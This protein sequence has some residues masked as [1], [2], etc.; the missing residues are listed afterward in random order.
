MKKITLL[1][2][3]MA[4][5]AGFSQ[6]GRQSIQAYL[7]GSRDKFG[8]TNQ[9]VSDW[10]IENE[11][12]G[13]GTKVTSYAIVQ[14]YQGIEIF[15]AQS[16]VSFKDGKVLTAGNNFQSNI[17]GKVN[18]TAPV[19]SAIQAA[20]AA[21]S[22]VGISAVPNFAV[23]ETTSSQ[24]LKLTDGLQ[25]DPILAKLVYQP[26]TDSK[27][28]LA[29]AFQF[30][31]PDGKH[32][33]DLRI[34]A[35]NGT[36][37][38]KNDL[39]INCTFGDANHSKHNH[40]F[41]FAK[42]AFR[43]ESSILEVESG[44]YKVIP[45]NYSSPNHS[46][47]VTIT[48]PDNVL[49]SPW[50]WHDTN[51]AAGNEYTIT[52]GN[53]A[54]AY[55]DA[56]G[57]NSLGLTPDGT[58]TLNFDFPYG[59][60]TALP[61]TYTNAATTNL[62][63]MVNIMHDVWYQYGFDEANGNFQQNNY[64]RGGVTTGTGDYV[65]SEA[66]D[67]YQATAQTLNNA[68]FAPTAD[69]VRPR[70]QMFL[71]NLGAPPIDYITV[72]S[73]PAIAGPISTA[74]N[75]VFEGTDHIEVPTAPNGITADLVLV[76]NGPTPPGYNSA[77]Q[78]PSNAFDIA[79]K[80]A[81]IKRG[82]CLFAFK[83]KTAQD[84]GALGVIVMDSIPDNPQRLQMS[85]TG[86]LGITIPAVFV[87]KE[88]GDGLIAE[89][90]N[91]PVS[92]KLEIPANLYLFAD[93]DFDNSIIGHEYGHGISNRLIG[94]GAAGCM[95]NFEQM[96][97]GWSDWFSLM[98]QIK[99]GDTGADPKYIGTFAVNEPNDGPGL[100]LYPYTTN[101]ELNPRTL[102]SS[103]APFDDLGAYKYEI[104]ETWA[105]IMWDLAWGFIDQYGYDPNIYTGTGGNNMVM[106]L[107][108]DALKM[109]ACNGDAFISERD[110]LFAA[111]Q[112]TTGGANYNMMAEVFRRRGLGLNASSGSI[113]V[114]DDQVE[115][116]TAFPLATTTFN[117]DTAVKVYPNPSNGVFNIRISQYTGK[118]NLQVVDLNGRV[119]YNQN[120]DNFN[121]EKS[122]N[123]GSLQ[124]GVYILKVNTAEYN[125]S[126]KLIK[127]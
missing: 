23:T 18:A 17:A 115:D 21:Y 85:S 9:D 44:S 91:G 29:W 121:I 102:A 19:L 106:R 25:E 66:Q 56:N 20:T 113:T 24:K 33:W 93:G 117:K 7:D 42:N 110:L 98:M 31:S 78:P 94:S 15:N 30:Y 84:A 61:A 76:Q 63:Y 124:T 68:N 72:L 104:G 96:G 105:T 65:L 41:S 108:L 77:C 81:L 67:G 127:N 4:S 45:Y 111:D 2:A 73:P 88:V 107:A 46:P 92:V 36:L 47:F 99:T 50:G 123:L 60:Q 95:T 74:T 26:T 54:R 90:A 6:T 1:I 103:N 11:L 100:R 14:R 83:V 59:P 55:E 71:W 32:M 16:K 34:D 126:Q 43:N 70:I 51:G 35:L 80:I 48:N 114:S 116:F 28:K 53:N 10:S 49:A 8:L 122:I 86:I 22:K 69:G 27:L 62:F 125:Y 64:G 101:M 38:E 119:V 79:G 40:D 97:E 37:L 109:Q 57:D 39:V 13:N 120:D 52:R 58:A 87:T 12:T 82:S 3:F 89:M 75:N 118:V 112:A 5:F